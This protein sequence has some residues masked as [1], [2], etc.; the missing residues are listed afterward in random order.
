MRTAALTTLGCKVNQVETETMEGLFRARGYEIVPF[1]RAADVYVINTCSVTHLGEKKSRQLVRRAKRSNESAVIAVTGCYAQIAP[2]ELAAIEGVRVVVGTAE[3]GRIVDFVEAASATDGVLNVTGDIMQAEVFEDIPLLFAPGRTRAFLKIEEGCNNFCSFCIIPYARGP[4]RSRPLESVVRET[5]KLVEHGFRE[6]VLTG[7]HLGHYGEDL[8]PRRSLADAVEAVL[9][10]PTVARLRLGSMESIELDERL[11]ALWARE[12]RFAKHLHLPLQA[13]TDAILKRMNRKYGRD[14]FAHLVR[15]LTSLA[16]DAAISTDVI[17]GFPGE[18]DAL[19]EE[20]LS[21][22]ESLPFARI[23]VFPY[24]RRAGTPAATMEGQVADAVKKER[25]ARLQEIAE[26]KREDFA[27]RFLG[28]TMD[29]LL[30]TEHNG[31]WT[32]I[33]E[34]YIKVYTES[35]AGKTLDSGQ[36]IEVRMEKIYQDGLLG[37]V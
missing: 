37:T 23:H 2:E 13:G 28:R 8:S 26:R 25:A 24:S 22:I 5:E 14:D 21:F 33:T 31:T 15:R 12:E 4:V 7:I 30:E 18:T 27:R 1:D 20:G 11:I 32:G 17:V 35:C 3:R 9:D 19:F 36:M 10:I 6:I 16:P 29:V 34:N